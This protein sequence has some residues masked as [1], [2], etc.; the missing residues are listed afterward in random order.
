MVYVI[1]IWDMEWT[2]Q[3]VHILNSIQVFWVICPRALSLWFTDDL[4]IN[5][6]FLISISVILPLI[7]EFFF[8]LEV[9]DVHQHFFTIWVCKFP[10]CTEVTELTIVLLLTLTDVLVLWGIVRGCEAVTM[11]IADVS[12]APGQVQT[13]HSVLA[14]LLVLCF[15][16]TCH[17]VLTIGPCV[18]STTN[19]LVVLNFG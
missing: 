11:I 7:V 10:I 15:D 6:R 16:V 1:I 18:R 3:H 12:G 5:S 19:T 9:V 8:N 2:T 17:T 14:F 4:F 13:A